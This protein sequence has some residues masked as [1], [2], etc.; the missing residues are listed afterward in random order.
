MEKVY[1]LMKIKSAEMLEEF[2]QKEL[3]WRKRELSLIGINYASAKNTNKEYFWRSG[4]VLIYAHWEGFVKK[5]A[6][7]YLSYIVFK[8]YKYSQL[9]N[10]FL[11]LGIPEQFQGDMAVKK[12]NSYEVIVD[13]MTNRSED[14]F[15]CNLDNAI[16]TQSNLKF[17]VF[18]E[19]VTIIDIKDDYFDL[20]KNLIDQQLLN[21]R[22]KIAHGEKIERPER[23]KIDILT[24]KNE[25]LE[26]IEHFNTK[27]LNSLVTK[28]Y[29]KA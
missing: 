7:A 16:N 2:L 10:N 20:K 27:I 8:G 13:F 23:E 28:S 4:I 5:S 22:N 3:A 12:F 11:A 25:I 6:Q 18:N 26:I 1:L 21:Y 17:E 19:I 29:L 9:K 14:K 15:L 24:M